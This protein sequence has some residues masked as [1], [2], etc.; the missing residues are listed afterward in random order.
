MTFSTIKAGASVT[1]GQWDVVVVESSRCAASPLGDGV[2]CTGV[3]KPV[4]V[5]VRHPEGLRVFDLE[6]HSI[7]LRWPERA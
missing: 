3:R 2:V 4:A 6:G 5:L 7:T 1:V